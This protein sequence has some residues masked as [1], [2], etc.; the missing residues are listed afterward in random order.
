MLFLNFYVRN[1]KKRLTSGIKYGILI[2]N[3]IEIAFVADFCIYI[4]TGSL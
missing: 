1:P 3:D 2:Q 4:S